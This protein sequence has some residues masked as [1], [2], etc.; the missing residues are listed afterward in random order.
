[1]MKEE[2]KK[3][4]EKPAVKVPNIGKFC[5]NSVTFS[6]GKPVFPQGMMNLSGGC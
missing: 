6:E 5:D 1:M 2:R 4:D 3:L